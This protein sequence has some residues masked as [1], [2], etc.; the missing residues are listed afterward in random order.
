ME[1]PVKKVVL[2]FG[3]R[4]AAFAIRC[5]LSHLATPLAI[6]ERI[7]SDFTSSASVDRKSIVLT[8]GESARELL[9]IS[10]PDHRPTIV[11][12]QQPGVAADDSQRFAP[13]IVVCPADRLLATLKQLLSCECF[14][15]A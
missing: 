1:S 15:D 8:D 13:D 14:A 9:A 10:A 12:V 5:I 4:K 11:I 2:V 7:L 6:E 3:Y